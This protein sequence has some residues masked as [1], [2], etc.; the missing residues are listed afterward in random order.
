[1]LTELSAFAFPLSL[2]G[3]LRRESRRDSA[4]GSAAPPRGSA[5]P[6]RGLPSDP[7]PRPEPVSAA[8]QDRTMEWSAGADPC[9]HARL[10]VMGVYSGRIG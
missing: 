10:A 4:A 1:M 6:T 9:A 2:R 7:P 5:P 8:N 3:L